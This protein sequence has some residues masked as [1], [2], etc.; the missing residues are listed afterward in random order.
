VKAEAW[1][2]SVAAPVAPALPTLPANVTVVEFLDYNCPYCRKMHPELQAL[3]AADSKVRVLYKQWPIFGDASL[4]AAKVA[5]AAGWQGKY[6]AV[7]DAFMRTPVPLRSADKVRQVAQSAGIDMPRLDRD[8]KA[9][10]GELN[11]VLK[12]NAEQAELMG[13]GGTPALVIGSTLV[14]GGLPLAMLQTLVAQQ[15]KPHVRQPL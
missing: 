6:D 11:T 13:L 3:I 10:S 12:R 7:H 1:T 15:R 4:Y 8:L 9:R 14:P 5:V 2:S